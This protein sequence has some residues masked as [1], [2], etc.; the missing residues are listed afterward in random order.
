[1]PNFTYLADRLEAPLSTM[2]AVAETDGALELLELGSA[3]HKLRQ[4]L[5][6]VELGALPNI[7]GL[8]FGFI[9]EGMTKITGMLSDIIKIPLDLI[10]SGV[11]EVITAFADI[12]GVIPIIGEIAAAVLLAVNAIV[13]AVLDL[14]EQILKWAGNLGQAFKTLTPQQQSAFTAAAINLLVDAA[15][16]EHKAAVE[17][18]L[19][20]APPPGSLAPVEDE[21]PYGEIAVAAANVLA[22]GAFLIL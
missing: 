4:E 22:I 2:D 14:P 5:F 13:Q 17:Q 6:G 15:P 12:V 16:P 11:G 3:R 8:F 1:M 7:F 18:K 21:A 10:S 20:T 9:G 19:T